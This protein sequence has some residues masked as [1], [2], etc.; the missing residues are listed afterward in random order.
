VPRLAPAVLALAALALPLSSCSSCK[1]TG[2]A[3]PDAGPAAAPYGI[4]DLA[5]AAEVDLRFQE[6][7]T[8][9]TEWKS[10]LMLASAPGILESSAK[11]LP[12]L[13][14]TLAALEAAAAKVSHPDDRAR[15]APLVAAARRWPP[16]LVAVRD[17]LVKSVNPDAPDGGAFRLLTEVDD[18]VARQLESYRRF[19]SQLKI[20]DAPHEETKVVEFLKQRRELE[21][22]EGELAARI[23]AALAAGP[24]AGL[25]TADQIIARLDQ[26]LGPAERIAAALGDSR[27]GSATRWVSAQKAAFKA[28]IALGRSGV[29]P[30]EHIRLELAYQAA[31]T[32]ALRAVAEYE[33]LTA[34]RARP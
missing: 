15:V 19:R 23:P 26:V 4:A 7:L 14:T 6:L 29:D 25:A 8:L 10:Q 32:E 28:L 2:P 30:A 16:A 27:S 21:R 9:V 5:R 12:R 17:D 24:D 22:V 13:G 20:A 31:K 11:L 18:E 1:P 34:A 33:A 3:A